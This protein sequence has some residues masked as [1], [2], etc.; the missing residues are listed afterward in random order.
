MI[1]NIKPIFIGRGIVRFVVNQGDDVII[2]Y[3]NPAKTD[4]E[5]V[6]DKNKS[7]TVQTQQFFS[8]DE[9][10]KILVEAEVIAKGHTK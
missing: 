1:W 5:V 6:D 9:L 8:Q 3:A 2:V 7:Y 4:A 10:L